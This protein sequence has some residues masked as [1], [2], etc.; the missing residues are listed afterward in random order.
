M[1]MSLG[2]SLTSEGICLFVDLWEAQPCLGDPDDIVV[3]CS[4]LWG[5][6]KVYWLDLTLAFI[7]DHA[8]CCASAAS[9]GRSL[10]LITSCLRTKKSLDCPNHVWWTKN[11]NGLKRNNRGVPWWVIVHWTVRSMFG[12]QTFAQL[13]TGFRQTERQRQR[14]KE[15][16]RDT[17]GECTHLLHSHHYL[18]TTALVLWIIFLFLLTGF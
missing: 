15:R 2:S 8:V 14:Q 1:T 3:S 10:H 17:E 9:S 13:R 18:I 11:I 7:F 16:E 12:E 6:M 4:T 5:M